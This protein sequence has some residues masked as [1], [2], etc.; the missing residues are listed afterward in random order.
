MYKRQLV[1]LLEE[2]TMECVENAI[3]RIKE[4][5]GIEEFKRVFEVI[6]TDNGCLLYTS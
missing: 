6:L 4:R 3:D 2:K 5:L 1:Y